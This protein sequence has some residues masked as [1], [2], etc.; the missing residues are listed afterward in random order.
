MKTQT[1]KITEIPIESLLFDYNLYPRTKV[2]SVNVSS[3]VD[4]LNAGALVPPIIVDKKSKRIVDGFHRTSAF[5]KLKRD[6][7]PG[8]LRNY[9]DE[10][11]L[12]LESMSLNAGH[13]RQFSSYDRARCIAKATELGIDLS[14]VASHLNLT[15]ERASS[16]SLARSA[17]A[18]D[19]PEPVTLKRTIAF[20]KG[21][22]LTP[23]QLVANKKLSGQSA[24]FYVNQ[25]LLL[26]ENDLI[27]R[28]NDGLAAGFER[29]KKFICK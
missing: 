10:Q 5:K 29:L 23:A 13:G 7:I 14:R 2:E 20:K 17:V 4:A 26:F 28:S 16:L 9:K 18:V 21:E 8:I 22:S 12:F 27:D 3:L 25:L 6:T 15:V 1:E 11:A 24:L 19:S